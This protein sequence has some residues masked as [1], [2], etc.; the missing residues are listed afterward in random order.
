MNRIKCEFCGS[1]NLSTINTY[2]HIATICNECENVCHH[3]K[4]KYFLE[5]IFPRK[6]AK[7]I[8]PSKAFLRLFRDVGDFNASD[9]Y[10]NTSFDNTKNTN[11]RKSEVEQITDQL[12][13]I[14]FN[15]NKKKILD[16]SGGPGFVGRY[17]NETGAKVYVTEYSSLEVESMKK[18]LDLDAKKF[19]YNCDKIDEI[20]KKKFDLIMVRSS[21]IFCSNLD[22]FINRLSNL[23]EKEGVIFIESIMPTLGE[24]FW[25]QQLEYKFPRIYSQKTIEE[26]FRKHKF[27]LMHSYTDVGGYLGVKFR[28]YNTID[29]QIFTWL[30]DFPMVLL[31]YVINILKKPKTDT[32]LNHKM[33]TQFWI[34][35][36]FRDIQH[37]VYKQGY[38]GKSK[39]FGYSYDGYLKKIKY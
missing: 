24:I 17:L 7:L 10:D 12:K 26:I 37:K 8:M 13:L 38:D 20:F 25:W 35:G 29:R 1:K 9:F 19:D 39:T 31:Y 21:I 2:K 23:L 22:D 30:I 5:F 28:S 14:N 16:I 11:W 6:L 27:K 4:S 3:K 32:T 36:K 34:K 18:K 15:P 33:L